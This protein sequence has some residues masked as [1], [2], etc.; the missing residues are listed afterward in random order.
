MQAACTAG[1]MAANRKDE[2]QLLARSAAPT[3]ES[4]VLANHTT[5]Q[6]VRECLAM[7]VS[8]TAHLPRPRVSGSASDA[9]GGLVVLLHIFYS[10]NNVSGAL[11]PLVVVDASLTLALHIVDRAAA[12]LGTWHCAKKR[13]RT[14]TSRQRHADRAGVGNCN[15]YPTRV[16]ERDP[17][18]HG[19]EDGRTCAGGLFHALPAFVKALVQRL[20]PH[21]MQ[22]EHVRTGC[23]HALDNEGGGVVRVVRVLRRVRLWALCRCGGGAGRRAR[24]SARAGWSGGGGRRRA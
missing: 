20:Q 13:T 23:R 10:A 21:M 4:H 17:D 19:G 9:G 5:R 11:E 24:C 7:T 6:A 2:I 12:G 1:R 15:V 18:G 8:T 22:R 16:H 3:K 14:R